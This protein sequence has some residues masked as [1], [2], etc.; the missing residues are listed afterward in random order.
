MGSQRHNLGLTSVD[1]LY[2][3][4]LATFEK[5]KNALTI[6]QH[7]CFNLQLVFIYSPAYLINICRQFCFENDHGSNALKT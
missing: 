1:L 5:M 6:K 3:S 4:A 7:T 2:L